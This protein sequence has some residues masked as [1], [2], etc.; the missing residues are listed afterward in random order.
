MPKLTGGQ[1]VVQ[2]L[3]AEGAQVAYGVLGSHLM[4]TYDALY[5]SPIKLI[6]PR[7]ED[8]A[9]H[10]ADAYT[11]VSN[12]PGVVLTT[13][14]PG[15]AGVACAMGEAYNESW[16]LLHISTQILSE[17]MG[18]EK[19][20]Y[21]DGPAQKEMFVPV[22]SWQH[23]VK[24]IGEIPEAINEAYRRMRTGR[25]RPVFLEIPTDFLNG[26]A[27][28]KILPPSNVTPPPAKDSQI[29][30]AIQLLKKAKRPI[31]WVGGGAVKAGAVAEIKAMAEMLQAPVFCTNGS[32]GVL[33]EDHPLALGNLLTL[34]DTLQKEVLAKGDAILAIGTRF[35]QRA[36]KQ[37]T[38]PMPENIIHCDID[39]AEFGKN[40]KPKVTVEGDAR[41]I[42]QALAS[43]LEKDGYQAE[44]NR[45]EETQ[46]LKARAIVEM[47]AR[48]PEVFQAMQ[49]IRA[50]LPRDA[51][52]ASQSIMGHWTRFGFE[53]YQPGSFL[54]ANTF[55]SMGF[56]FHAA[57]G[58]KAAFPDRKV[59]GFCGDGGF[60][61]GCGELATLQ[62][63]NLA[64]PIV[65]FNNGGYSI[66]R[67]RQDGRYGRN[68]GTVLS[69]PD[70][71]KLAEAFGFYGKRVPE[72]EGLAPAI[73]EALKADK[74]TII[75]VPLEFDGYKTAAE[76]QLQMTGS[77][78][79]DEWKKT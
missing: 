15:A 38:I 74:T 1:A 22:S 20:F 13:V 70:Y 41:V 40:Y 16:P 33:A 37:W 18:K 7:N 27:D 43:A 65:V 66:I 60:M 12:N 30:D 44:T 69:N 3:E 76:N 79:T 68:I 2:S 61:F 45:Y 52:V 28:F 4:P 72:I 24:S 47:K 55:G 35:S 39:P 63:Y 71:V 10:M 6:T 50:I 8:S 21:H 56:A 23:T 51:I 48:Q 53:C 34:S 49:D 46:T 67:Q 14:G 59:V 75:E 32:K 31:L 64:M 62:Q 54:F 78:S 19:G 36:T 42:L 57:V 29:K 73:E 9:G 77:A 26:E 5:D 25:P 11:R 17:H 58:A